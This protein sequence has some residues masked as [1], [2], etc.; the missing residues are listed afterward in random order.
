MTK[1]PDKFERDPDLLETLYRK[2]AKDGIRVSSWRQTVRFRFKRLLWN[3]VTK[4]SLK[5]KRLIDIIGS[6]IGLVLLSPVFGI[7]Y[8][9]ILIED[10]SPVFFTQ[11]R[12]GKYGKPFRMWKFRSMI[13]N[14]EAMRDDLEDDNETGGIIFKIRKDPRITRVGHFIRRYSMD[15]LPQLYNVLIGDMSLVGPRPHP[16]SDVSKYSLDHRRRLE[17][18]PGITC[19]WQV[20]GRSEIGF[21]KQ[22]DLD[23]QYIQSQSLWLDIILLLKTIPAV[24]F[25]RGAY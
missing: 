23:I 1:P 11:Q 17:I 19:F 24:I 6:L 9:A 12:I 10:G 20:S 21:E 25:G 22:V 15:E 18:T 3:V 8:L 4:G 13:K 16:V 14:A 7:V 2:Y 5:L